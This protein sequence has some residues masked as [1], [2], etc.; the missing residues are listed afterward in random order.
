M[1]R[2][3]KLKRKV[4][5]LALT[6]AMAVSMLGVL[7]ES[8]VEAAASDDDSISNGS[9]TAAIGDLGEISR[10]TIDNNRKNS[11][12]KEP[13]PETP[14]SLQQYSGLLCIVRRGV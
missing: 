5:S 8:T 1:S 11:S 7:P 3:K 13:K 14:C 6:T 10:L 4:T 9:L 2:G 12:G